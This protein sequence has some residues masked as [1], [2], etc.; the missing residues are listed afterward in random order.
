MGSEFSK[1]RHRL[2]TDCREDPARGEAQENVMR[3]FLRGPNNEQNE[4][5]RAKKANG[6]NITQKKRSE[7]TK[8]V[9]KGQPGRE[10]TFPQ[11]AQTGACF[12]RY[13]DGC[14]PC[15][16]VVSKWP[17]TAVGWRVLCKIFEFFRDSFQSLQLPE[18][19][20]T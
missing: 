6:N 12:E 17:C 20:R 15:K 1:R 18:G 5:T 16:H 13:H 19:K 10:K 14:L 2:R 3:T 9:C 7:T 4:R 8:L 11:I